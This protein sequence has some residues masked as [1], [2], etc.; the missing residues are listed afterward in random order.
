MLGMIN[1]KDSKLLNL[2][3]LALFSLIL[4]KD[5][6]FEKQN[7]FSAGLSLKICI[8]TTSF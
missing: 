7:D 2:F 1:E 4:L 8:I 3:M 6:C 5:C